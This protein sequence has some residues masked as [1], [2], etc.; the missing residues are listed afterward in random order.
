MTYLALSRDSQTH[1][2]EFPVLKPLSFFHPLPC[3]SPA[4]PAS[5]ATSSGM[6]LFQWKTTGFEMD[7]LLKNHVLAAHAIAGA[8]SVTLG[9][10][11]TYPLDTLKTLAQ[12]L[13]QNPRI[14]LLSVSS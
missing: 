2:R 13:S 1:L 3:Q 5:P 11:L 7:D 8:G 14:I 4:P 10:L 6:N 12:V 9:T